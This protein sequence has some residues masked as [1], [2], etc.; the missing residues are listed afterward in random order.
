MRI[1]FVSGLDEQA[2]SH[3][4]RVLRLVPALRELGIEVELLRFPRPRAAL[5]LLLHA[6]RGGGEAPLVVFQKTLHRGLARLARTLGA[7]VL[8]D[9]DDGGDQRIDGSPVPDAER[10]RLA[11]FVQRMD[12]TVVS[13]PALE[14][15]VADWSARTFV[16]PTCLDV[17]AYADLPPPRAGAGC[18]IGWVGGPMARV[19]L[20]PL[21]EPLAAVCAGG[22]AELLAVGAHDPE[23]PASVPGR[24]EPWRLALEPEVFGRIDVGIMPLPHNQRAEMKAGFKLLQYMAAGRPVV[25]TPI[26]VNRDIVRPGENGFLA[27]APGEWRVA[28]ERLVADPELC[29][30]LGRNGR[31]LVRA[32]YGVDRAASAWRD[33]AAAL[34]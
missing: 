11:D 13:V 29:R 28:L 20:P 22:R 31:A 24:F 9:L 14:A 34:A 3:R 15:W 1:L 23:L 19:V 21:A 26:G 33:V 16:I 10:A 30:R 32:R 2:A 5:G 12:A 4:F 8:L 27:D 6:C 18:T 17:D 7:R 25:A